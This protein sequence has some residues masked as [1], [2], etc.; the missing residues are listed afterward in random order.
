MLNTHDVA[1]LICG[2]QDRLN[3]DGIRSHAF[4]QGI[5]WQTLRS[6]NAPFIPQLKSITDTS[7]FPTEDLNGT[8][9]ADLDL[10]K[11]ASNSVRAKKDLA[12]VG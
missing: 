5:D 8:G 6:I 4:F 9:I 7:Y 2:A 3:A 11:T 12:F 1:S 10:M